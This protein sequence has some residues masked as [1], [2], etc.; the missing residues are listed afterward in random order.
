MFG[1]I[2]LFVDKQFLLIS[3]QKWLILNCSI[4]SVCQHCA[5]GYLDKLCHHKQVE[6]KVLT[7]FWGS[8]LFLLLNSIEESF[9]TAVS[10]VEA[11]LVWFSRLEADFIFGYI[12]FCSFSLRKNDSM[13]LPQDSKNLVKV[14]FGSKRRNVKRPCHLCRKGKNKFKVKNYKSY[15]WI[16]LLNVA[17]RSKIP[18][19]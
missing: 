13:K 5:F 17:K 4:S 6:H 8:S 3:T 9:T 12:W 2:F 10:V 11:S 1:S 14:K 15:I 18:S 19:L 16:R 7:W